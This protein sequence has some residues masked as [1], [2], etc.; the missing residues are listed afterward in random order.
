MPKGDV[1][2]NS[3]CKLLLIGTQIDINTAKGLL[4]KRDKPRELKFV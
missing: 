3:E 4:Y 2:I 1:L